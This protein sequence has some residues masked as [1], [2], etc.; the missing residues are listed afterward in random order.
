MPTNATNSLFLLN[1]LDNLKLT[2]EEL[3]LNPKHLIVKE[4]PTAARIFFM[5]AVLNTKLKSLTI[6]PQRA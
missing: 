4:R 3:I 2:A 6:L 1:V 5:I